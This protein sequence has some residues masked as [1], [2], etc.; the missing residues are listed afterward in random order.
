MIDAGTATL[1]VVITRS[2]GAL[3]LAKADL[4]IE[5]T[6]MG[7]SR[8]VEEVDT[9]TSGIAQLARHV[10]LDSLIQP[11]PHEKAPGHGTDLLL[12]ASWMD[13]VIEHKPCPLCSFPLRR[14]E[15]EPEICGAELAQI[16]RAALAHQTPKDDLK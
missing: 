3:R 13:A 11:K 12:V 7:I 16:H 5:P 6:R 2:L 9:L 15:P 10:D 1:V 14:L 4:K 8:I